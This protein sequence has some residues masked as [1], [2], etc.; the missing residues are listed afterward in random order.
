VCVCESCILT[1]IP[2]FL[3]FSAQVES[4]MQSSD[5]RMEALRGELRA[6]RELL[7]AAE[8][9]SES[10]EAA[11]LA[12]S[13]QLA[14]GKSESAAVARQA[15]VAE[16]CVVRER[17]AAALARW[18]AAA[19]YQREQRLAQVLKQPVAVVGLG[20]LCMHRWR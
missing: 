9:R 19:F 14:A 8:Q 16:R 15:V 4:L 18:C 2:P 7:T 3:L 13:E 11:V 1:P 12:M 17:K 10:A 6:V 20:F 5:E